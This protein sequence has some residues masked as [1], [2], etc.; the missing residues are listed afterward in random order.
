MYV[1]VRAR[2]ILAPI[3]GSYGSSGNKASGTPYTPN[4]LLLDT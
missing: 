3:N 1:V 4:G 2:K